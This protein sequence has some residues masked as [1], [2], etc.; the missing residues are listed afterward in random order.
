MLEQPVNQAQVVTGYLGPR[1]GDP[2]HASVKVLASLLGGGM[3]SRLLTE[4]RDRRGLAY[5]AGVLSATR[6][7]RSAFITYLGTAPENVDTVEAVIRGE[8]ERVRIEPPSAD[9][10]SRAKA[11]VL[12]S[13]AMDRRT[14][15]RQAWYLAFV[16]LVGAARDFPLRYARAVEAVTPAEVATAAGRWLVRPSIVVVRPPRS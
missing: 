12:G 14:N 10:L 5:A 3:G 1:Q 4:V 11:R 15:A 8:I 16:E 6:V 2:D 9:E 7:G 13:L